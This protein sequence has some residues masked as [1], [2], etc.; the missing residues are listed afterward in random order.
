MRYSGVLTRR[1]FALQAGFDSVAWLVA[2]FV[3]ALL[4]YEFQTSKIDFGG[5]VVVAS[6]A[7]LVQ[8]VYGVQRG[9]YVHR[10]RYGTLEEGMNCT[11]AVAVTTAVVTL[12]NRFLLG[13][14]LPVSATIGAAMAAIVFMGGGRF[15]FRYV[16][17]RSQRPTSDVAEPIIVFGAGDAGAKA[18]R[19][20]LGTPTSP[21]V[22]VALLDDNLG[23][24]NLRIKSVPVMGT[25]LDIEA[26]ARAL[27]VRTM[28]FAVPSATG[29]DVRDIVA[30]ADAAGLQTMILPSVAEM[31]GAVPGVADIRP[32]TEADLLGRREL[33][34]DVASVAGYLT[35]KRV[36]VTGAGG[37]IG[38][39]L[40]RHIH[41]FAPAELVMLD[42]D[43]SALQAVQL[44][45]EGRA[46]LDDPH[47]VIA[48]IRDEGRI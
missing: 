15:A 25:R 32:L 34:T 1:R 43:E 40:C 29:E 22:P 21:Y 37:S 30:R 13:H 46:L 19:A 44:S 17:E 20:M 14:P 24:S 35:G 47:L 27:D 45:I 16:L 11:M 12:A 42:R 31:Y 5:L 3:S 2:L 8:V 28:L 36:L 6:T 9:L 33:Q 26:L 38:S 4:R 48:D 23:L 7:A 10:W 41:R 39:E 18:I